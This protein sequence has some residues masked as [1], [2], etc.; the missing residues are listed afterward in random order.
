[1]AL[2]PLVRVQ[3]WQPPAPPLKKIKKLIEENSIGFMFSGL[4]ETHQPFEFCFGDAPPFPTPSCQGPNLEFILRHL[5]A[6]TAAWAAAW[7]GE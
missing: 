7:V 3:A 4:P 1:M 6:R 5:D 2:R